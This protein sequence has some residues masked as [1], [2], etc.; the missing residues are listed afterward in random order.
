M[1][2]P[3]VETRYERPVSYGIRRCEFDHY[4]LRRS[5]ARVRTG[6]PVR[7]VRR[8]EG[9]WVVNEEVRAPLLVGA[10]G[11]FCPVAQFLRPAAGTEPVVVAQEVEFRMEA[12]QKRECGVEAGIP[13]LYFCPDWK[14][15]GWCFRKG[16]YLNV[17]LGRQDRQELGGHV[18]AFTSTLQEQRR[19]PRH[20]PRPWR[21]HA[22]LLHETAPR[23][24]LDDGVLLVGDA[25]GLAYSQSGEGIRTAVESGILAA[26]TVL[27][28]GGRHSRED[29][30]AYRARVIERF[31]PRRPAGAVARLAA[32]HLVPLVGARLLSS[33]WFARHV[34]LD[35]W[36]LHARQPALAP[37]EAA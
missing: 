25:A 20:L 36:F 19:I 17:G 23:P 10:G 11:H 4:L 14:G 5:R 3:L 22:Y 33:P 35:R 2:R 34:L 30:E 27:E 18:R 9:V 13:E 24:L 31:G 21:G 37:D 12:D 15:Y 1:G 16:S 7:T 32:T 26:R 6:T 8:T 29:L 28:A